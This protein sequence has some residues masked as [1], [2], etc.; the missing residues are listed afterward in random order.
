MQDDETSKQ[1]HTY[2]ASHLDFLFANELV[3]V[4]IPAKIRDELLGCKICDN[5]SNIILTTIYSEGWRMK[6]MSGETQNQGSVHYVLICKAS[7]N[8][9]WWFR[10]TSN[11]QQKPEMS[12]W[13]AIFVITLLTLFSPQFIWKDGEWKRCLGNVTRHKTKVAFGIDLQGKH[14][15]GME[16]YDDQHVRY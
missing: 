2:I 10:T 3:C 11:S 5:T 14:K 6:E 9:G 4:N 7:T 1:T 15:W 16:V 12:Y 8:G 13:V